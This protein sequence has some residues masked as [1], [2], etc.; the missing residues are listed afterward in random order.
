MTRAVPVLPR[1]RVLFVL[2]SRFQPVQVP[3]PSIE[4]TFEILQV[5][6]AAPSCSFLHTLPLLC[7]QRRAAGVVPA[8]ARSEA[9]AHWPGEGGVWGVEAPD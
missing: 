6:P 1:T 9:A 2:R 7:G 5:R 3:E 8:C 4:E